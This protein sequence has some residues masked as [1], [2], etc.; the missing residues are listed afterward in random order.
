MRRAAKR[1]ATEGA[2]VE[3]LERFGC[4][5]VRLSQPGI[6]DLLVRAPDGRVDLVECKAPCGTRTPAQVRFI[7][8]WGVVPLLRSP[9]EAIRWLIGSRRRMDAS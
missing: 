5:V 6:P 8:T 7:A 4:V 9:E 1:D 3:A 2:I